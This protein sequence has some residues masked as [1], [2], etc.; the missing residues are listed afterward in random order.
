MK[1]NPSIAQFVVRFF[2]FASEFD[3]LKV[4]TPDF[5][6]DFSYYRRLLSKFHMSS[7]SQVIF[8]FTYY[9]GSFI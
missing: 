7:N 6:N 8:I 5:Q 3:N 1:R 9:I 4:A 2:N